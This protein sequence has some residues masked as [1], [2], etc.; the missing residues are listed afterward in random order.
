MSFPSIEQVDAYIEKIRID[1]TISKDS[2]EK[3][4]SWK[5]N[6]S[7]IV[8]FTKGVRVMN[9][10]Q[11]GIS[12]LRKDLKQDEWWKSRFP[13]DTITPENKKLICDDFDNFLRG[14]LINDVYGIFESTIRIL[15]H[16]FSSEMFPDPTIRFSKIYPKLLKEL[17]LEKF[18]PLLQIW[19]N[20]RNSIHNDGMFIPPKSKSNDEDIVYD[21]DTYMFRVNKPVICAGW[22]DLCELSYELAKATHQIITSSKISNMSFIEEPG[23]KYWNLKNIGIEDLKKIY[24]KHSEE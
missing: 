24:R 19:S 16:K 15:A 23:S 10:L 3:K 12:H 2:L 17:E 11:I 7:R 18:I 1:Y 21:G 4:Y 8:I 20:I 13:N 5:N 6:D 14:A 9:G 22:K